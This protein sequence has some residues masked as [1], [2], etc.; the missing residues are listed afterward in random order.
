MSDA[1]THHVSGEI[2]DAYAEI[3]RTV[4]EIAV[5]QAQKT[6]AVSEEGIDANVTIRL[7][8]Q[9]DPTGRQPV[10]CCVC[11]LDTDGVWTC[12]GPCC[13]TRRPPW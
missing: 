5:A 8:F 3:G 11:T 7:G 1:P 4:V 10:T 13:P 6:G 9:P 12:A 2:E